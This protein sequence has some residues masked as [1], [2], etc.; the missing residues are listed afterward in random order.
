MQNFDAF[1]NVIEDNM[2]KAFTSKSFKDPGIINMQVPSGSQVLASLAV[3]IF[4]YV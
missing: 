2:D 3:V 1:A 4:E